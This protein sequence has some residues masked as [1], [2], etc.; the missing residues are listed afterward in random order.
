MVRIGMSDIDVMPLALGAN[1]FGWTAG[2]SESMAVLD[3]FHAGGGSL[4]DTADNY[5]IWAEGRTGGESETIIGTWMARRGNR[6]RVVVATKVSRHPDFPGLTRPS[7]FGGI[8]ASL[9]RLGTDYVDLYYAHY[10]DP[11]TPVAESAAAF[12]DLQELGRI[13][14]VGLSN[15]SVERL[16]EWLEVCRENRWEPPIAYQPHYNLVHRREYEQDFAPVVER[17]G[18]SA[19][20]YFG[21]ASG[22]LSGKYRS[23]RDLEGL[24]RARFAAQYLSPAA[25]EVL[26]VLDRLATELGVEVPT[27][28]LSWLRGR[29]GVAAPIAS[30]RTPEQLDALLRSVTFELPGWARE[31]LD[32]ASAAVP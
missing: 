13:R 20:P 4:I 25:V 10:D 3:A 6:E 21:L 30:A 9:R 11:A 18:M 16:V 29:A 8:E 31:R 19:I 27:L 15:Y 23:A 5:P 28:A 24:E 2:A 22:F 14:H 7:I 32:G 26:E 1:T 12:H 17:N